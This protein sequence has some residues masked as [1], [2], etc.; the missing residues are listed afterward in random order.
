MKIDAITSSISIIMNFKSIVAFFKVSP[1]SR[2]KVPLGRWNLD[3]YQE[4]TLK[5]KYATEDNCG[6]CYHDCRN[7][8][9]DSNNNKNTINKIETDYNNYIY[10]MGYESVHK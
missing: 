5:T 7:V 4:T 2:A 8:I 9:K 3:N 1:L 10:M 6:I